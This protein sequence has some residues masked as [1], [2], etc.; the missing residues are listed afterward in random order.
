[1]SSS[2]RERE[3][4]QDRSTSH[5]RAARPREVA[6]EPASKS[7]H[8]V[9]RPHVRALVSRVARS[10]SF[11]TDADAKRE[12]RVG[13]RMAR[14]LPQSTSFADV[15]SRQPSSRSGSASSTSSESARERAERRK[16][17]AEWSEKHRDGFVPPPR[18]SPG[19]SPSSSSDSDRR[20]L[21]QISPSKGRDSGIM[22]PR[23][24]PSEWI[25]PLATP[26]TA[27]SGRFD[28]LTLSPS[29][30]DGIV[31]ISGLYNLGNT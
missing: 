30:G 10:H 28:V 25:S 21:R 27:T 14:V 20:P 16:V 9:H 19:G 4:I 11:T 22:L 1:M 12:P 26:A 5:D 6:D 7:H 2:S 3:R 13:H 31:G 23:R 8:R 17:I 18:P 29:F 24:P 15:L